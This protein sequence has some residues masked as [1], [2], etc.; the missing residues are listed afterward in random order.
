M[1]AAI[2][3][4]E[5][6]A[7]GRPSDRR[8]LVIYLPD[9]AS[10]GAERLHLTMAPAFVEADFAVTF[11]LHRAEGTLK[12]YLPPGVRVVS[13]DCGRTIAGLFPLKRF[14]QRDRP[15][16]LL[17]NL[18]HNN[19]IAIWAAALARV[20]TRVITSY[21]SV[22]SA[23][24]A[25]T[26]RWQYRILPLLSRLFLNRAHGIVAVSQGVAD[27]L[28][29]TTG[30]A[31]NRITVIYNPVVFPD[32]DRR[33]AESAPHPWLQNGGPPIILGVG[34][35]V[36]LKDFA[37]LVAA[38][39]I[40]LRLRNARL[41]LLGEG[42]AR[43]DLLA[44]TESLGIAQH[45]SLPGFQS[46]PFPFMRHAAALVMSSAYEGFGNV[47]AEA[48]ACGTPVVSTD[49]PYGPAEIL[50]KG[51]FGRLVPV[52]DP[53]AMAKAIIET[54]D[55]PP[56]EFLQSRGRSFTVERAASEYIRLFDGE[57]PA[58]PPQTATTPCPHTPRPDDAKT[59][60]L[61]DVLKEG[62][63]SPPA[64]IL[65]VGCGT[66]REAGLLARS[67]AANT[68]GIDL[69]GQFAFDHEGSHPATLLAMDACN[70][71]FPNGCFDLVYSFHALEHIANPHQALLE[72]ARVL[73]PGGAYLIGTPNKSRLVGYLG[74]P[75]PGFR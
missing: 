71:K 62:L 20:P 53:E 45:V 65:V 21:H 35:L 60:A 29:R 70:L 26:A 59:A 18:G 6:T 50:A 54:L 43:G 39:T 47:L 56:A 74:A 40:T 66:G 24:T 31:R 44:L 28:A 12:P 8:S 27:D 33:M 1:L 16:I 41:I 49:C 22:L 57:L 55:H 64:T 61:I 9:L 13:M 32:F 69:G 36:P 15:D 17:S 48:L 23:E 51:R 30:V 67:F 25:P 5:E 4:P 63:P 38:F 34:R 14:L 19:I 2:M 72:M 42:P 3:A 75:V 68:T 73:R 52:G 11:L 58:P 7:S 10:G 37:T 46:N